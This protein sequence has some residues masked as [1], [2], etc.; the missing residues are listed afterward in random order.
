MMADLLWIQVDSLSLCSPCALGPKIRLLQYVGW[1]LWVL[2]DTT[3]RKRGLTCLESILVKCGL[4]LLLF[5]Y[6]FHNLYQITNIRDVLFFV[7]EC[8]WVIPPLPWGCAQSTDLIPSWKK[9]WVWLWKVLL[10]S[11]SCGFLAARYCRAQ[12]GLTC[13]CVENFA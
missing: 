6:L 2:M 5:L 10:P 13:I 4:N 1:W 3:R 9:L 7:G 12:A 11:C 8:E